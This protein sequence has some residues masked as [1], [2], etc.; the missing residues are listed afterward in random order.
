MLSVAFQSTFC[1]W[2]NWNNIFLFLKIIFNINTLKQYK[3]IKKIILIFNKAFLKQ[4]KL[5][6]QGCVDLIYLKIIFLI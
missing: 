2:R 4:K 3:N 5:K 6:I 1:L